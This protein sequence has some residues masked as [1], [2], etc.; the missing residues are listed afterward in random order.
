MSAALC[1]SCSAITIEKLQDGFLLGTFRDLTASAIACQLCNLVVSKCQF[2]EALD[3]REHAILLKE[4]TE[5]YDAVL[6]LV[7][8]ANGTKEVVGNFRLWTHEGE[9]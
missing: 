4:A 5:H 9:F 8:S 2:P 1:Q 6:C 3:S 7:R